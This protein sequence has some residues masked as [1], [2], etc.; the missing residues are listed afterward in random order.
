M[1]II[2]QERDGQMAQL[3]QNK[4]ALVT[5]GASGIGQSTAFAFAREGA[6][7]VV[8]DINADAGEQV[9]KELQQHGVKTLFVRTDV[10]QAHEVKQLIEQIIT[11]FGQLDYALNNVGGERTPQPDD[12]DSSGQYVAPTVV[13]M[14]EERWDYTIDL[15][16]KSIWLSMK[17]EIP[18][19][20]RQGSGVIVNTAS[21]AGMLITFMATSAYSAAKAG[22]IHLSRYAAAYYGPMGIRVNVVVPGLTATPAVVNSL[23]LSENLRIEGIDAVPL[24]SVVQP[25]DVGEAVVWL[26]SDQARMVTG[27][28]IPVDAGANVL[29]YTR[30][31]KT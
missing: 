6:N 8:T 20:E 4:V 22:L 25:E 17:Y 7:V 27:H 5:G 14:D 10:T 28:V 3:F 29:R 31:P 18:V 21:V 1:V 13:K 2:K 26:C 11:T 23:S 30:S 24:R 16:L 19:M 9:A 15:N 12:F